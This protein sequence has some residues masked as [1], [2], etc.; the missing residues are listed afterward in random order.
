MRKKRKSD[1]G[2]ARRKRKEAWEKDMNTANSLGI[3]STP[4]IFIGGKEFTGKKLNDFTKMVEEAA[5]SGQ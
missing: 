5:E 4:T 2:L 3:S 1:G